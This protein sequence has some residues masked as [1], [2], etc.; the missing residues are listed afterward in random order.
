MFNTPYIAMENL[1]DLV[2]IEKI[3]V[4]NGYDVRLAYEDCGVY[5]LDY[6][7]VGPGF[8]GTIFANEEELW[9]KFDE[10]RGQE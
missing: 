3:L 1:D 5:R 7:R 4:K 2:E 6:I 10:M 9:D 8:G